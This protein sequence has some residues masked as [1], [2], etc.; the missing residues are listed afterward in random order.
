LQLHFT[1]LCWT[2]DHHYGIVLTISSFAHKEHSMA[3]DYPAA[4]TP[5][6]HQADTLYQQGYAAYSQRQF[7]AARQLLEQ[8]LLIYREVQHI[9]GV[10]RVLHLLGNIACEQGQYV[11]AR[12]LHEEVLAACRTMNFE[13]G[14]ASSLNNLGLVAGKQQQFAEGCA[15]LEESLGIYQ[16]LGRTQEAAAVQVN[17]EALRQQHLIPAPDLPSS[18]Q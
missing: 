7:D 8:C 5:R 17:L 3:S 11:I 10:L 4:P 6:G 15:L 12:S 14:I 9:P 1:H 2:A 16:V 13:E 18:H